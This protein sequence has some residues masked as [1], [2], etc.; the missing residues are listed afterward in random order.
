MPALTIER[1]TP[2]GWARVREVRL[3]A[4]TDTP[5]A[6]GMTLAEEVTKSEQGWRTQLL[7]PKAATWLA[8]LDGEDV[9][10]IVGAPYHGTSDAAGLFG[11][12]VAPEARR[13]AVGRALVEAH[14]AWA[15]VHG[16][17]RVLLDVADQNLPAARFYTRMGFTPNGVSGSLPPPRQHILEHQRERRL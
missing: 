16:H 4:L 14:V 11:M 8:V 17:R 13:L 2:N 3:R 9:G 7:N 1:M 10:M 15:R 12:W 6:L 5:D